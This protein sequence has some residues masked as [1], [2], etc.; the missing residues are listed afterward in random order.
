MIIINTI[1]R[2]N[3]KI[4]YLPETLIREMTLT[5]IKVIFDSVKYNL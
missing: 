2:R 1:N 4:I 3:I 5:M